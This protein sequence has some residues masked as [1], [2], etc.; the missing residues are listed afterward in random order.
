[1]FLFVSKYN[2][3]KTNT[4]MKSLSFF[5]LEF[6]R[7]SPRGLKITISNG[8]SLGDLARDMEK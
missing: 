5:S 7:S 1:M 2:I 3:E 4:A 8:T 6:D